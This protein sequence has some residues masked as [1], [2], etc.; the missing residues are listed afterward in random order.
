MRYLVHALNVA[1]TPDVPLP[2]LP[3]APAP[4][5]AEAEA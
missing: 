4:T 1:R 2:E 3:G 5:R